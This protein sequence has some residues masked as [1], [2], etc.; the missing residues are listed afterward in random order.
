MNPIDNYLAKLPS[1]QKAALEQVR[2][3]VAQT[4]PD[5]E[6]VISYGMPG[7]KYKGSYLVGFAAFKDH[8]S[9]FP[10]SH[11]VEELQSKLVDFKLSKGTIQFTPEKP[12]P[13][14]IIR[15]LLAI[16]LRDIV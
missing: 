11:P 1:D 9:L 12:I 15:Q 10:T 3:V 5:A 8:L 4:V 7:F 14:P 13:E 6:E 2:A 16:R